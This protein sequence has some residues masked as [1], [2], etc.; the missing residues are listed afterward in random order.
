M[1]DQRDLAQLAQE[2]LDIQNACNLSGVVH[3]WSRSISRLRELCPK[4]DTDFYN[5]HP[6]SRLFADKCASLAD[7]LN[8]YTT[9]SYFACEEMAKS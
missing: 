9:D 1:N 2:A 6:I 7:P 3:A 8:Q 5:Q 4:E